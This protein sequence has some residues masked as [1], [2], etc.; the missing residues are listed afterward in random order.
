MNAEDMRFWALVGAGEAYWESERNL[1][2]WL[3]AFLRL[4]HEGDMRGARA[5]HHMMTHYAER[6]VEAATA[7]RE[8]NSGPVPGL[9]PAGHVPP[10]QPAVDGDGAGSDHEAD[11]A[12]PLR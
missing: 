8:L 11:A 10:E 7:F 4:L 1:Y 6:M 3:G 12:R 9:P 2:Y 5:W